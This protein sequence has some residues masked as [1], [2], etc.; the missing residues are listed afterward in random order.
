MA[1]EDTQ[2]LGYATIRHS[3]CS[4]LLPEDAESGRCEPCQTFRPVL[5]AQLSRHLKTQ[6]SERT[7]PSSHAR[8]GCLDREELTSRL[9]QTKSLQKDASRKTKQ[10]EAKLE[11]AH[12]G[13]VTLWETKPTPTL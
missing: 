13:L 9:R 6:S 2:S 3:S 8:Y 4:V 11:A 5:R 12:A 7:N 10:L 1:K